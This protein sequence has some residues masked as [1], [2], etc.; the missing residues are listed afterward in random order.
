[1]AAPES[2]LSE[3]GLLGAPRDRRFWVLV[4]L[5]ALTRLVWVIW[6]HPP[7]DHV[8]SDMAH[9]VHRARLVAG[10]ELEPGMRKMAWQ[11]YGTHVLLAIPMLLLGPGQSALEVASFIWAACSA[12]T[13]V[14]AYD[15]AWLTLPGP[16]VADAKDDAIHWPALVV[17]TVTLLWFPFV[18]HTGYFTSEAP[19]TCA[20]LA[21]T[22]AIARVL[23]TGKGLVG[24]GVWAALAFM[25]RPQSGLFLALLGLAW[26]IDRRAPTWFRAIGW[27]EAARFAAPVAVALLVSMLRFGY[28]TG[29]LG[30]VAE[31]GTMNL[32]AGRCHNVVTRAYASEAELEASARDGERRHQRRVSLPGFR[33]LAAEGPDHQLA[34]RPALGTESLD[35]VG[36]IGDP[37]A[38]AALRQRCY[39][40][41][42]VAGQ[43]RY[44]LVNVALLAVVARPWPESSDHTSPHWLPVALRARDLA[45]LLTPLALFG[46]GLALVG[47]ARCRDASDHLRRASL[48][49]C[50]LQLVSLLIVAA[51]FFG[52]PRLR[53]PYDP[54]ALILLVHVLSWAHG[55]WRGR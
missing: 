43:L 50:A 21:T 54:Y 55:A 32:T 5:A 6:V 22:L 37:E 36:Y 17:A 51:V 3:R 34:L 27:R 33:A 24:A 15:L 35:I 31:N 30:V 39:A 29:E 38:H 23:H 9:Y 4:G 10:F 25:L 53:T 8:F 45:A 42:G 11:A 18:S 49:V 19:F 13:V 52:T 41:T 46:L 26:L 20:L 2:Q 44:S 1:M 48:G 14:L 7:Q 16:R 47:W 40:E 12:A 28:Y